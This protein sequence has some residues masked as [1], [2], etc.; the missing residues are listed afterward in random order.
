[1]DHQVVDMDSTTHGAI[2]LDDTSV[3]QRRSRVQPVLLAFALV[4]VVGTVAVQHA[5]PKY[6]FFN[7][8]ATVPAVKTPQGAMT[9]CAGDLRGDQKCNHDSTH[10]V[11]AKIGDPGTSFWG[12]TGQ[13]SWCNTDTYGD[14]RIGCPYPQKPTWCIC[15]WA[16]ADWIKGEGCNSHVE[17][18]CSATD[19]CSTSSGLFFSYQDYSTKL[20][21]AR[22]CIAQKCHSIWNECAKENPTMTRRMPES[23][24][25][26]AATPAHHAS[27]A[28][29]C[30]TCESYDHPKCWA[31]LCGDGTGEYCWAYNKQTVP[32][33]Y[34]K[35]P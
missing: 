33:D 32:D 34:N 26:A 27:A 1:M 31:G 14:G 7:F 35:C 24:T 16:T 6:Q 2:A 13:S 23:L 21:P 3:P 18:D 17:I 22:D 19:I 8:A 28:E 11:C 5:P 15:K 29:A 4:A 30:S 9:V 10:R 25:M 20:G 12:H